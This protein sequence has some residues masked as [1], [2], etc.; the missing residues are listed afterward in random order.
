MDLSDD[1]VQQHS[2]ADRREVDPRIQAKPA[3][4]SKAARPDWCV[5]SRQGGVA[6]AVLTAVN[7]ESV[8]LI[9]VLR[10]AHSHDLTGPLI[11]GG[12]ARVSAPFHSSEGQKV[13]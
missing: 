1:E 7:G 6:Y 3:A 8:L 9:F 10:A 4:R 13:E 11:G 5:K 2:E 12:A